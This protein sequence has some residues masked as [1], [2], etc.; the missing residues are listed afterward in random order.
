MSYVFHKIPVL[1]HVVEI[2]YYGAGFQY[3][4]LQIK[5]KVEGQDIK[6][7]YDLNDLKFLEHL[8]FRSPL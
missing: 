4:T 5:E 7:I 8:Y 1:A 3:N 2:A 6:G